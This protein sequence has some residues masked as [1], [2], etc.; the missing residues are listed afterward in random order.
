[1]EFHPVIPVV[2]SLRTSWEGNIWV[3]RRGEEPVSDGLID[4]L[5]RYSQ[6]HRIRNT[7]IPAYDVPPITEAAVNTAL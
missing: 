7:I 5:P 1:M 3:Q 4:V 6:P 2:R